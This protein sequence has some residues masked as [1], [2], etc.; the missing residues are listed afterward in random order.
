MLPNNSLSFITNNVK[1]MQSSKKRLKSMQYFKDRIGPTGVLFLQETHSDSKVEQKWFSHS[2]SI[3]CGVLN[4]YFGRETF[5]VKK[6]QTDKQGRILIL[7]VDINDSE[8]ILIT[9]YNSNT[10]NEQMDALS[11]LFE[12]LKEFD[13][14]PTKHL[15]M[16][17]DFNLFFT[18]KLEA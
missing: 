1:G 5:I 3:S 10:E 11:S 9:L 14:N 16:A 15:V 18:S 2:K 8:Y 12:L 6:Q 7:D 4:A 13:T 17:G